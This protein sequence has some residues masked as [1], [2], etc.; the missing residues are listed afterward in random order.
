[1][2]WKTELLCPRQEMIEIT[3]PHLL[4]FGRLESKPL[5][6]RLST[7]INDR[8]KSR[9]NALV[10]RKRSPA[11][12]LYLTAPESAFV[13]GAELIIDGGKATLS[14]QLLQVEEKGLRS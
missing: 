13:L 14:G 9:S 4:P 11:G 7:D 3:S 8:Q 6:S 2:V 12:V 1:M 5:P 10:R